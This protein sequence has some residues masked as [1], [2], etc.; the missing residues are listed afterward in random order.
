M[1][2]NEGPAELCRNKEDQEPRQAS[3]IPPPPTEVPN[4]TSMELT[5]NSIKIPFENPTKTPPASQ[6]PQTMEYNSPHSTK[7]PPTPTISTHSGAHP[8]P[9]WIV[10]VITSEFIFIGFMSK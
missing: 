6:N 2:N 3:D 9:Q 7:T 8:T 4:G 5:E 1:K 10:D